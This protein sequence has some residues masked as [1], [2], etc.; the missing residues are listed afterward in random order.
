MHTQDVWFLFPL[1]HSPIFLWVLPAPLYKS[2]FSICIVLLCLMENF[3]RTVCVILSLEPAFRASW[4]HKLLHNL[5]ACFSPPP[6]ICCLCTDQQR[7]AGLHGSLLPSELTVRSVLH[8]CCHAC[9]SHQTH[10]LLR[11]FQFLYSLPSL[12]IVSKL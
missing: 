1:P 8:S 10:S 11:V 2:L 6:R 12:T 7:I 9:G 3:I 4:T 5:I